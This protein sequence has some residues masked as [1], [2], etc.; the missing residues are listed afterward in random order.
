[1]NTHNVDDMIAIVR[2]VLPVFA[3]INLEDIS[4]PRCFQVEQALENSGV[5]VF[6][7]E[8]HGLSVVLLSYTVCSLCFESSGSLL[9]PD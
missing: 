5:P 1:M 2:N 4:A 8:Q 9:C 3:G 6:Q 7:D